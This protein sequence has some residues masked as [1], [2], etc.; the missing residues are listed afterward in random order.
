MGTTWQVTMANAGA[1]PAMQALIEQEL[2]RLTAQMSAWEP[3]SALSRFNRS[4]GTWQS[5]PRELSEVLAHALALAADTNGAFDPTVGP[6]VRLWSIGPDGARRSEPPGRHAIAAASARVGW[7]HITFDQ[8][9]PR[10]RQPGDMQLDINAL[11]PGFAVD[12]M[13][14]V[15]NA[16]G[17]EHALVELGGELRG[18]GHK[19]DGSRWLV[20]VER[21]DHVDA[22]GADFD[23]VVELHDA[24]LGSSGDYR[25]GFIHQ[26]RRYGHTIDPRSGE[27]VQHALAAVTVL[28]DSA[29]RADG[30]AA[31]LMVLGPDEGWAYAQRHA[32]AAA[33][34]LR[35]TDGSYRRRLTDGFSAARVR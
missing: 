9:G 1:T 25:S 14:A 5:I 19:Q 33:F 6:L 7:Q 4:A 16:A 30:L 29:L 26:G 8:S 22:S 24:A 15:L 12:R 34:T 23:L 13:V 27:P 20:A 10:L 28:A 3:D 31:A 17:V 35:S 32:L 11:G 21:P 18:I 2:A